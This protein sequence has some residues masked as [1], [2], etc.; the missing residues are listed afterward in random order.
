MVQDLLKQLQAGEA[1]F[2]DVIQH[3]EARYTHT[4][5]AFQNGQQHNAATENQGSAKVFSFAQLNQLD[6]Q[7]TLNL[8]AEHY[9]SVLATPDASDHQNIRQF[10]QNGWDGIQFEGVA[11]TAK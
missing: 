2:V 10:M 7:Q 9:A 3:I 6:Q 8:F 1:K 11:L 4:P 5:T